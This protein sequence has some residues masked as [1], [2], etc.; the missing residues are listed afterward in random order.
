MNKFKKRATCGANVQNR[1]AWREQNNDTPLRRASG[2]DGVTTR[3]RRP[4][5]CICSD[6]VT[7]WGNL[8]RW[9]SILSRLL[10]LLRNLM[11]LYLG[12]S[13]NCYASFSTKHVYIEK[14]K[15]QN[16]SRRQGQRCHIYVVQYCCWYCW[17]LAVTTFH[18]SDQTPKNIVKGLWSRA[19]T[20]RS[21]LFH[22]REIP[23]ANLTESTC[24]SFTNCI[25]VI[26]AI[27][28]V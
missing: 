4:Y 28:T 20:T 22:T 10:Y 8:T 3:Q 11:M 1:A 25:A 12:A 6:L 26:Q 15:N 2:A 21:R 19:G 14:G 16:W 13:L 7:L 23:A 5:M 24:F 17:T 27:N 9:C 18:S